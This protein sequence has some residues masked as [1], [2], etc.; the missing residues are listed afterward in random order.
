MV[1][2][3]LFD[4]RLPLSSSSGRNGLVGTH[5]ISLVSNYDGSFSIQVLRKDESYAAHTYVS[6]PT[7]EIPRIIQALQ[8]AYKSVKKE[9]ALEPVFK[10]S[11]CPKEDAKEFLLLLEDPGFR[12]YAGIKCVF[13]T[14]NRKATKTELRISFEQDSPLVK[15][16]D[17]SSQGVFILSRGTPEKIS[18][19]LKNPIHWIVENLPRFNHIKP[20]DF[21]PDFEGFS[22]L[23]SLNSQGDVT[24]TG[25]ILRAALEYKL[26]ST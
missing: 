3:I 20:E 16:I 23:E 11:R 6:F 10:S 13:A 5:G 22:W 8:E 14:S 1:K 4:P 2:E 12:E 25:V 21:H 7:Q 24:N 18:N 26:K 19:V 17:S 15:K 9:D